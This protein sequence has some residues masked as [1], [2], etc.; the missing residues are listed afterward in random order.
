VLQS[1]LRLG[2]VDVSVTFL[3][4][5]GTE[6]KGLADGHPPK[7]ENIHQFQAVMNYYN[8]FGRWENS[9]FQFHLHFEGS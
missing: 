9:F 7:N 3:W 1:H 6:E 5:L 2:P 8:L 4:V